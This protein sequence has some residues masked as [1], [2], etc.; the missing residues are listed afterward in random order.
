MKLIASSS[1]FLNVKPIRYDSEFQEC[2]SRNT[3]NWTILTTEL[4]YKVLEACG[5]FLQATFFFLLREVMVK[6]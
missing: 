6:N 4:R 5:F 2:L 1:S 3:F